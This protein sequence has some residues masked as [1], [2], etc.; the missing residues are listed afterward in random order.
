[1]LSKK[2]VDVE[3]KEI[4]IVISLI[5]IVLL[6]SPFT[7]K[8]LWEWYKI[9]KEYHIN[10][11]ATPAQVIQLVFTGKASNLDISN[12]KLKAFRIVF[13]LHN[14]IYLPGIAFIVYI[15]VQIRNQ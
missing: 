7:I 6:A 14:L 5:V 13:I 9:K 2:G 12:E 3:F 15:L 10:I 4:H 8:M 11:L 1:M